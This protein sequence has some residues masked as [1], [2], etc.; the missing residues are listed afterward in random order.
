VE[1]AK[2]RV[3]L[4]GDGKVEFGEVLPDAQALKAAADG[5]DRHARELDRAGERWR[6]TA[7]DAFTAVVVMVPTM[8]E[9]FGQWKTSR[10]VRG[11]RATGDAFNVVSRLAD[12]RDI[13]TGLEV[14]YRG[15]RPAIAKQD[16]RQ[17]TLTAKD[18]QGLR[19]FVQRLYAE[20][21]S[22]RRF[23]AQQADTL[24]VQAQ[25]RGTAIAGQVAQAA[26]RLRVKIVQ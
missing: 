3:D 5:F 9:Y 26:A 13:L 22:G 1:F 2:R 25:D 24:G 18:L 21:R 15:I 23:T 11:D 17:S 16:V 4:D 19:S 7:S 8:T 10:F 14:I 20:E 12:I 6:P